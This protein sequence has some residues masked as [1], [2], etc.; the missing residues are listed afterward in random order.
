MGLGADDVSQTVPA[1]FAR[2]VNASE[3]LCA[4][5][6]HFIPLFANA[7]ADGRRVTKKGFS[8]MPQPTVTVTRMYTCEG[9]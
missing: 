2:A 4:R 9:R 1:A 5:R 3:E 7:R 6:D 8:G